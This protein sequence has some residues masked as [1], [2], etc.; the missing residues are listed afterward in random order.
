MTTLATA[1]RVLIVDDNSDAAETLSMML[2]VLGQHTA[3]AHDGPAALRLAGA[4]RPDAAIL[5]IGLPGMNG[6]E[7]ASAMRKLDGLESIL[8][9]ALTGWNDSAT[10]A[11]AYEAGF[12]LHLAKPAAVD[13]LTKALGM[14]SPARE[15]DRPSA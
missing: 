15:R 5:D 9:I 3:V 8:L 6:Y 1:R 13:A 12:D 4:F 11:R 14:G 2:E 7:L 10:R